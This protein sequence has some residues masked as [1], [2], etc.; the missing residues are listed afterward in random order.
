MSMNRA[1]LLLGAI[2]EDQHIYLDSLHRVM[3]KLSTEE[4]L[5][6]IDREGLYPYEIYNAWIE[7]GLFRIGFPEE[8][9]GSAPDLARIGSLELR[10]LLCIQCSP[11]HGTHIAQDRHR[12]TKENISSRFDGRKNQALNQYQ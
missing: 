8:Y 7:L 2:S 9:G 10:H 5:Q 12:R 1:S 3:G 11:L 4:Y 6:K